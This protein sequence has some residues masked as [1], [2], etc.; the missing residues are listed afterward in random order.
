MKLYRQILENQL[1]DS[2]SF[3][4]NL[5]K[6]LSIMEAVAAV[7]F[8]NFS[9]IN[10][11]DR[12]KIV[13]DNTREKCVMRG[14]NE[15]K[16]SAI[17]NIWIASMTLAKL[18]Q[19]ACMKEWDGSSTDSI[20]ELG[21]VSA[22]EVMSKSIQK[23]DLFSSIREFIT[24]IT[25][26]M[27]NTLEVSTVHSLSEVQNLLLCCFSQIDRK[28]L[29]DAISVINAQLLVLQPPY[30]YI[31][32]QQRNVED[33]FWLSQPL[34][35]SYPLTDVKIISEVIGLAFYQMMGVITPKTYVSQN[36]CGPILISKK[37]SSWHACKVGGSYFA[38]P[39][40]AFPSSI[41]GLADLELASAFLGDIDVM[42]WLYDNIGIYEEKDVKNNTL[43]YITK[44]DA[45]SA[46]VENEQFLHFKKYFNDALENFPEGTM[47]LEDN[48]DLTK[49]YLKIFTQPNITKYHDHYKNIFSNVTPEM[50]AL[51]LRRL[52]SMTLEDIHLMVTRIGGK[53]ALP[54]EKCD[55]IISFMGQRLLTFKNLY[56]GAMLQ[57][58]R[59]T[60]S[61][62]PR[63]TFKKIVDQN[64]I[65]RGSSYVEN[66]FIIQPVEK[67]N[68]SQ[69]GARFFKKVALHSSRPTSED[70]LAETIN[71]FR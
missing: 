49:T 66:R 53:L 58:E 44:H 68:Y 30:F 60:E 20:K 16:I 22:Q 38:Q 26:E 17:I 59:L 71:Y 12:E 47:T 62:I 6:R 31:K 10:D 52:C 5:L 23:S 70:H 64:H 69:S 18:V 65:Q 3:T 63:P 57:F 21:L 9:L 33:H 8:P 1:I 7:K 14:Y 39:L 51:A 61:F 50:R 34:S 25:E 11:P 28:A 24:G 15:K 29:A 45:G 36:S 13:L 35:E 37:L 41:L 54:Q 2:S 27:L 42:G 67:D 19:T 46:I 56:L 4:G 43:L 48:V 40:E 55:E 32:K